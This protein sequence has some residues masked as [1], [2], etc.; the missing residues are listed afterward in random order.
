[1]R[2]VFGTEYL[3]VYSYFP[4]VILLVETKERKGL[5]DAYAPVGWE[6]LV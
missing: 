4:N 1:M 5:R 6:L 3:F 2:N